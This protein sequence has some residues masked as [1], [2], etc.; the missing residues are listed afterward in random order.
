MG[1]CTEETAGGTEIQENMNYF[2]A[3]THFNHEHAIV[4]A[5]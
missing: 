3:R 5:H 2:A 4:L 1:Q